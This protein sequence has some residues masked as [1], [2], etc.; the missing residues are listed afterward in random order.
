M[1]E[2]YYIEH[3]GDCWQSVFPEK[4]AH[5]SQLHDTI[6]DAL[7]YFREQRVPRNK[8]RVRCR[9][10]WEPTDNPLIDVCPRCGEERA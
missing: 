3:N 6:G 2:G 9:H 8:I 4:E 5:L 1:K 10:V 7:E